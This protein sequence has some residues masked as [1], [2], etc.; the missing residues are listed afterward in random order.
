MGGDVVPHNRRKQGGIPD[1]IISGNHKSQRRSEL[2]HQTELI[3]R[4]PEGYFCAYGVW[5]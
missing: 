1:D 4:V 3:L 5:N 2:R